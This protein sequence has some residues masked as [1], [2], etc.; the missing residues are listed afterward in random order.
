MKDPLAQ[1]LFHSAKF[2][3]PSLEKHPDGLFHTAMHFD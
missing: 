3:D 1:P 2:Q